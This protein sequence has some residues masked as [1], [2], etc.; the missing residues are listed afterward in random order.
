MS[1]PALYLA[2]DQGSHASRALVFDRHGEQRAGASRAVDTRIKGDRVEQDPEQLLAT[3]RDCALDA[4]REA[5]AVPRAAG[6]A[7]QRSSVVCWDRETGEVLT[8][9][10]SWR[11]RRAADRV[12]DLRGIAPRVAHLTGLRLSPHYGA[13]KLAWCL[14]NVPA[15][16]KARRDGTLLMGPL[17]SF[18][19]YRLLDERP[20]LVDPANAARTLLY[21]RHRYAWADELLSAFEIPRDCLPEPVLNR[22]AFGHLNLKGAGGRLPLTVCTG[23]QSAA[24]F[25]G[26]EPAAGT[27]AINI[28]TGA[29]LQQ[30]L[31]SPAEPGQLLASLAWRGAAV[32]VHT[33]EG[34]VNGAGAALDWLAREVAMAR[35]AL[36][37]MLPD[38]LAGNEEPPL[39]L[40]G[41]GG[42]G[43]PYW[44]ARVASRFIGRGGSYGKGAAVVESMV[45]LMV[46]NLEQMAAQNAPAR[47]LTVTGGLAKL[48]G[49]CSRLSA[50]SGI[51]VERPAHGEATGR[52]LAWLVAGRPR[53]WTSRG[54]VKRF[55]ETAGGALTRRYKRWSRAMAAATRDA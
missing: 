25:A 47:R 40:N 29:F 1:E 11:D 19:L 35:E 37:R 31:L 46:R 23:D 55:K 53:D 51:P 33:L 17:S 52:G 30:V 38:A 12:E 6:L 20:A 27:V 15:V 43:S 3:L 16:R 14:E 2:L 50:L 39:F 10:L 34:T 5:G 54:E 4:C 26:G 9:V 22:H 41:I 28:G 13:S 45:F 24:L 7:T 18:L 44:K 8:P 32:T 36:T 21:D 42:V 48:D 49:L